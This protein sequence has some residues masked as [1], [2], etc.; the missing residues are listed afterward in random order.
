MRGGWVYILTNRKNG[1]L[2]TGVTSNLPARMMQHREGKGSKFCR[3][4]GID[5][6]VYA[7][8][9]ARVDDAIVR[10]KAIKKWNRAWK[11]RLI[12]EGNPEWGDLFFDLNG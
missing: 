2:Y 9:H 8:A 6:L 7:E 10:E 12:E 4:H 5:R 3:E 1:A 11:V